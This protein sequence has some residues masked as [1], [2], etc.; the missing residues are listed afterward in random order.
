M[1]LKTKEEY[2]AFMMAGAFA[3]GL[4]EMDTNPEKYREEFNVG[5]FDIED[6]E[7]FE[8]IEIKYMRKY[9]NI[10]AKILDIL[11]QYGEDDKS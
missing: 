3:K 11:E 6:E 8:R 10:A 5:Y 7:L 2:L 4:C 1:K 9:E